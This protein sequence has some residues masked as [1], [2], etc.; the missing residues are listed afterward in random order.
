MDGD[1]SGREHANVASN[2]NRR[3]APAPRRA[4]STT[5][6]GRPP[7]NDQDEAVAVPPRRENGD[8]RATPKTR[9]ETGRENQWRTRGSPGERKETRP[10]ATENN[11]ATQQQDEAGGPTETRQQPPQA[12]TGVPAPTDT[13]R[14][15]RGSDSQPNDL[16]TSHGQGA[17]S[18]AQESTKVGA[19]ETSRAKSEQQE[20]RTNRR[21]A[22][23]TTTKERQGQRPE[24][25]MM[26]RTTA[27]APESGGDTP[28]DRTVREQVTGTGA[29]WTTEP[30]EN[31]TAEAI[32]CPVVGPGRW[33]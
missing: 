17:K 32:Y 1:R 13:K 15:G 11:A 3:Q 23:E 9:T 12:R 29:T 21:N 4:Q 14:R 27:T 24:E 30:I 7:A 33:N 2:K 26:T 10:V 16:K 19:T 28:A 22:P 8:H 25:A 6:S 18:Q 31:S 5:G 20:D